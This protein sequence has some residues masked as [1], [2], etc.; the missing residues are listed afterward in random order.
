M[1][2]RIAQFEI[3]FWL[4]SWMIWIFLLVIGLLFFF[5]VS[6]DQLTINGGLSN[7]F[8]NAPFVIQNYYAIVSLFTLLMSTAF[9]NSAAVRD[10]NYNTYQILFST[11]MR[12]RD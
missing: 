10:F 4:R 8:R 11:P 2:L 3:R 1:F 9:V 5:A 7:T 6:S 12:R